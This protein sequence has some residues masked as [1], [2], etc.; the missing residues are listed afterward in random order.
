VKAL[1]E[2]RMA[3]FRQRRAEA[4]TRAAARMA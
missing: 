3:P 4:I 2:D 1:L